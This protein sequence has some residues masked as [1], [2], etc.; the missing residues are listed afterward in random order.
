[1]LAGLEEV[2]TRIELAH[3]LTAEEA[4]PDLERIWTLLIESVAFTNGVMGE[5]VESCGAPFKCDPDANEMFRKGIVMGLLRAR[6][7]CTMQI[8]SLDCVK[9]I[10]QEQEKIRA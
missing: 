2:K 4:Q 8:S 7:A 5:L 6:S 3:K 1:M 9:A 10:E